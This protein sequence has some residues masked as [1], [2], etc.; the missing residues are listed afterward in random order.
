MK[1]IF[2]MIVM[3]IF[4]SQFSRAQQQVAKLDLSGSGMA[5]H[6][7]TF[8]HSSFFIDTTYTK[9]YYWE[10][11]RDQRTAAWFMLGGGIALSVVGVIGASA[12]IF[13]DNNAADTYAFVALAGVGLS[14]GSIPVFIASGR[15]ARKAA[16][17]S[18]KTQPVFL[19]QQDRFIRKAQPS[20]SIDIPL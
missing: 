10:K 12:T 8:S 5:Q 11:S 18:F 13:D 1:R 7:S 9:E 4:F 16:T 15:N 19:P 2:Y 14:L 20:I 17:L 6:I 3:I